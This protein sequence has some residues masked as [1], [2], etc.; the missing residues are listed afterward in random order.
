MLERRE[1]S[2]GL[3]V[4]RSPL[5]DRIGVPHGFSTRLGGVSRK[6]FDTLN[7]QPADSDVS[8]LKSPSDAPATVAETDDYTCV[9]TNMARLAL[10]IG[11]EGVP[12][13]C[14]WQVH[15]SAS[16]VVPDEIA[17][18]PMRSPHVI[19]K[20]DAIITADPGRLVSIRVA[21]CVP[22]LLAD[23]T[24]KYVAAV[25]AGWR[26]V[27]DEAVVK[28]AERMCEL[29]GIE[30]SRFIAAIGPCISVEHFEVGHEVAQAFV[31][32][33]LGEAVEKRTP[34]PHVDLPGAVAQQLLRLGL[35][36]ERI[37]RTDRCTYR[38]QDEFFS[39]RRDN[40]RTGRMCAIIGCANSSR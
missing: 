33:N 10:A 31:D 18:Q 32:A 9:Q 11:C 23:D 6:P 36:L 7:F 16:V 8:H 13:S 12:V 5:L 35:P 28:S 4:Y 39:H 17:F 29:A 2:N 22:I 37:D 26:G 38:D 3:V 24:G 25:H 15:G 40:G 30:P 27:V 20:A 14:I 1:N 21:D 34:R 19:A